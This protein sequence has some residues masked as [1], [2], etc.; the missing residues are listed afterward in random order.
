MR[1]VPLLF[2]AC[3][4]HASSL[5]IPVNRSPI[6]LTYLGVA[7]WQIESAGKTILVD[8]Y[9]SRPDLAGTI[10]SD[11]AAVARHAP[12]R[13]DL[14]LVAHSHVDHLLDAPAVA[15]VTGAHILGSESTARVAKAAGV[16]DDHI[17]PIKGGEDYA[18]DG[19]SVRVI[20]GLHS[21]L[22]DKHYIGAPITVV[23]PKTFDDYQEGGTFNYLVRVGGHQVFV[24]SSANFIER[25][26]DGLRPNIAIIATGLRE[27][28][29][30]YTC[31]LVRAL[32]KP[33]VVYANHFD[34]WRGPPVDEPPSDDM[35]KFVEEVRACS[36]S[37]TVIVPK[38]FERMTPRG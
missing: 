22:S 6:A 4:A 9:F 30:D 15:K 3:G 24:Q 29:H 10:E 17:I 18:F 26:I 14:I 20:P 37:T 12:K 1:L 11:P 21:A 5:E 32:G 33:P 27:E 35:K 7:G 38:H 31:R 28:I 23:P 34:N 16:A 25:E 36:P 2:V 8:P 19:F 13:A